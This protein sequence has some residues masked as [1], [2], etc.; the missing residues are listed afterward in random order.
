MFEYPQTTHQ[1]RHG[2][3]GYNDPRS[4]KP[5]LRDE[6]DF[7]CVYCLWRETWSADG[8]DSFCVEHLKPQSRY[9]DL[10]REYNNLAYAC[11]G[12]NSAKQDRESPLAEDQ[13]PL[14]AHLE[15]QADGHVAAKTA[16]GEQLI[17]MC[18]LNRPAMVNARQTLSLLWKLLNQTPTTDADELK[19]R[20]F[21][22]PTDLPNLARLHPPDGNTKPEGLV[23]S[24]FERRRRD[25]LP[26]LWR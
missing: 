25:E 6:F 14:A 10:I 18:L 23:S 4:F 1:R 19:D 11:R 17:E 8:D 13:L 16:D 9:P 20:L 3:R 21:G 22:F 26:R 15:L 7:R 5:W 24:H 12:C 2:P